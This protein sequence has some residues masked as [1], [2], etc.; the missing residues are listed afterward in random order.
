MWQQR[1]QQNKRTSHRQRYEVRNQHVVHAERGVV[2]A[3]AI[4]MQP[5]VAAA[6]AAEQAH[7]SQA[8]V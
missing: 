7:K 2:E 4:H 1:Q 8:A 3:V 6:A 5:D